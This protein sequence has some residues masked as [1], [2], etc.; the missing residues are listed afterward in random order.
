M[1]RDQTT[2]QKG[3]GKLT[4]SRRQSTAREDCISVTIEDKVSGI[5]L[6]EGEMS[7]KDF[8]QALTGNAC[9]DIN[10]EYTRT[11]NFGLKYWSEPR[12]MVIPADVKSGSYDYKQVKVQEYILANG[13]EDGWSVNAYLGSQRSWSRNEAGEEVANYSVYKFVPVDEWHFLNDEKQRAEA[14]QRAAET[15]VKKGRK[16]G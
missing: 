14:A 10:L 13:Q 1:K 2:V 12:S 8:A 7:L 3:P 5:I 9:Q 16:R 6:V 4:I 15:P 11:P